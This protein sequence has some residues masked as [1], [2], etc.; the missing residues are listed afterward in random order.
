VVIADTCRDLDVSTAR[1]HIAG[2]LV[3]NDISRAVSSPVRCGLAG[4]RLG[5][6][7]A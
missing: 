6:V 2:Y 1:K 3:A 5:L 7:D 4:V